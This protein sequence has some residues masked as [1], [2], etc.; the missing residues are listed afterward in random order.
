MESPESLEGEWLACP[1]CGHKNVVPEANQDSEQKEE[2]Q[3][4]S[5]LCPE[6]LNEPPA[7]ATKC[8]YCGNS[9]RVPEQM[10]RHKKGDSPEKETAKVMDKDP[11]IQFSCTKCGETLHAPESMRGQAVLCP[12]CGLHEKIPKNKRRLKDMLFKR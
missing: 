5:R 8:P 10:T 11:L 2:D 4:A 6:C 3:S 1:S 12:Q 9:L 7:R